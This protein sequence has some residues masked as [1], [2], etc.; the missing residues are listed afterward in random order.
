MQNAVIQQTTLR[1]KFDQKIFNAVCSR[2]L[3]YNTCSEDPAVD[4]RALRIQPD[5][6][7]L[8]ITSAGCNVLGYALLGPERIFA[9]DANPRQSALLELKIAGIRHLEFEDFFSLFGAGHHKNFHGIYQNTLR[10]PL[11]EFARNYWDERF[12]DGLALALEP[13]ARVPNYVYVGR[14]RRN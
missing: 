4:R 9:V 2:S 7:M 3:A 8:V 14:K 13:L 12:H 6:R 5:D 10:P 1:D 11:G